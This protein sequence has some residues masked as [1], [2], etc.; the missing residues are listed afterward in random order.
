MKTYFSLIS[1]I[2]SAIAFRDKNAGAEIVASGFPV[3]AEQHLEANKNTKFIGA[4]I[5][6]HHELAALAQA[7]RDPRYETFHA[8]YMKGNEVVGH[9]AVTNRLPSVVQ[10]FNDKQHQNE[11]LAHMKDHMKNLGADGYWI[12]HNHPSGN[13]SPSKDDKKM[14][15]LIGERLPGLRG[16][17]V[18]NSNK[19]AHIDSEGNS[20][21][22]KL[23][24]GATYDLDKHS[25]PHDV[26]GKDIRTPDD[27]AKIG[28]HFQK[29]G[30]ATII[31][32]KANDT[33]STV[34]NFPEHILH[35]DPTKATA[36]LRRFIQQT[37]SGGNAV[38]AINNNADLKK[39]QHLVD[40]GVVRNVVAHGGYAL[41]DGKTRPEIDHEL[42]GGR[43]RTFGSL[44]NK[45]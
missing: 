20:R 19:F 39:Y 23:D 30:H 43:L 24:S 31:G 26:I 28:K 18:V 5:S 45:T 11:S 21:V 3:G 44:Y 15:V 37:G 35:G 7:H 6:D 29:D 38:I 9:S 22:H 12:L 25:M 2:R 10:I 27:I 1:E 40:S 17:V 36:S 14:T 13:P 34:A 41:T 42:I 16:H 4:K 8:I 32:L 33:V